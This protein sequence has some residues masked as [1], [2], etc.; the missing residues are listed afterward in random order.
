[1]AV[2]E[3]VLP[4]KLYDHDLK[5]RDKYKSDRTNYLNEIKQEV[6]NQVGGPIAQ[7]ADDLEALKISARDVL[8][9]KIMRIYHTYKHERAF[10][11]YEK[12]ALEILKVKPNLRIL[13][14]PTIAVKQPKN[15]YDIKKILISFVRL[16]I[17]PI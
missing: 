1:M 5:I 4:N 17:Y 15:S 9:E 11:L 7:N 8:R 14:L 2:L 10:P 6:L 3:E 13:L 16:W 12:E